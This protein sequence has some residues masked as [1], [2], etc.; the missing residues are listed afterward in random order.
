MNLQELLVHLPFDVQ[1][2][3]IIGL[4]LYKSNS[5]Y[6]YWAFYWLNEALA[7]QASAATTGAARG[8]VRWLERLAA[9]YSKCSSSLRAAS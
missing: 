3:V 5:L 8:G 9:R 7:A 4:I 1:L 6:R 2:R